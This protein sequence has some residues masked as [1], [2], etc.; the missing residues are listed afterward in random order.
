M[1][2]DGKRNIM[3]SRTEI[4]TQR[5]KL[6][7]TYVKDRSKIIELKNQIMDWIVE[8]GTRREN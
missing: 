5:I 1:L 2:L 6:D 4:A 7:W 3:T 8:A